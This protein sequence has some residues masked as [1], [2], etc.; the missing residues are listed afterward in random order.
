[1]KKAPLRLTHHG[2]RIR[3]AGDG[4]KA[5]YDGHLAWGWWRNGRWMTRWEWR[6]VL[7]RAKDRPIQQRSGKKD[8]KFWRKVYRRIERLAQS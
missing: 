3:I 6:E 5:P 7:M 1:M 2:N 4:L 8:K